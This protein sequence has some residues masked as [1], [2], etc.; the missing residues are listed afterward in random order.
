ME[1]KCGQMEGNTKV[2]GR[3][4]WL[5]AEES[6]STSIRMFMMVSIG[7]IFHKLN[8]CSY[9]KNSVNNNSSIGNWENDKA[10]GYGIYYHS[11]G[12]RYEGDWINDK[13]HGLGRETWS[14]GS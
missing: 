8:L 3:M 10:H 1:S 13:Q 5:Q 2:I 11:N 6:F 4:E 7:S 12:S 14:D 9:I